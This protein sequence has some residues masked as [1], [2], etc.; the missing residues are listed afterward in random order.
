[1]PRCR[2][3]KL[4]LLIPVPRQGLLK[5]MMGRFGGLFNVAVA[6]KPG[7]THWGS[8]WLQP[9]EVREVKVDLL[10]G[11]RMELKHGHSQCLC[12]SGGTGILPEET[13]ALGS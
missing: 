7:E 6:R 10:S 11:S 3:R 1:M 13:K 8:V 2:S 9:G 5:A 4:E 12:Y